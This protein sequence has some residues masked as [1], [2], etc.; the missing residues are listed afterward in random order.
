MR[1][2]GTQGEK[3]GNFA[4]KLNSQSFQINLLCGL[5]RSDGSQRSSVSRIEFE[6]CSLFPS[7]STCSKI[8]TTG[9]VMLGLRG[10]SGCV[11]AADNVGSTFQC[12]D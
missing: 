2:C 8:S 9:E 6:N 12:W 3:N 10:L 1:L 4:F 7:S 5:H 11:C